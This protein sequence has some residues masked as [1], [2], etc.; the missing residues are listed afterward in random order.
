[1]LKRKFLAILIFLIIA[2]CAIS[3]VNAEEISHNSEI[4]NEDIS[5]DEI[6]TEEQQEEVQSIEDTSEELG[7]DTSTDY[8]TEIENENTQE[9]QSIDKT[10][11]TANEKL[12]QEITNDNTQDTQSEK[13]TTESNVL[14]SQ[15]DDEILSDGEYKKAKI[16]FYKQT[17]SNLFD[18]KIYLKVTDAQ[19]GELITSFLTLLDVNIYKNGKLVEA[20]EE[21]VD[22][23]S[24]KG[25][26]KLYDTFDINDAGTYTFKIPKSYIDDG[27]D[28]YQTSVASL[29]VTLKKVKATITAKKLTVKQK[30]KKKL[31]IKVNTPYPYDY[32][33]VKI[34][35]YTKNKV[36]SR[37]TYD[38]NKKGVVYIKVPQL[39]PGKHKVTINIYDKGITGKKTTYIIVKGKQTVAIKPTKL[40]TTYKSGKYFKAKVINKN[41]KKAVKGVKITLKVFTGKNAKTVTLKSNSKGII[42]Y[43]TS[44]L[45]V[46]THKVVL[47]VKKSKYYT[48]KTKTSTIKIYKK[49][50][51]PTKKTNQ[52]ST[53]GKLRTKIKI[54]ECY[55][56]NNIGEYYIE[57]SLKDSKGHSLSN[58]DIKILTHINL[59]G[60]SMSETT[61]VT[62][63]SKGIAKGY[64][65]VMMGGIA[66]YDVEVKFAGDKSH[67]S[68]TASKYIG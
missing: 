46:G 54:I 60:M 44:K 2:T 37:G 15:V 53:S 13:T 64:V 4:I 3:A 51:T 5:I 40:S 20:Q 52:K 59:G 6:T 1:M 38:T 22:V 57:L 55:R 7:E 56:T 19:T 8:V 25:V 30:S 63:D 49:K 33:T 50:T 16:T 39:S 9:I 35:I 12:T 45:K 27:L 28:I 23:S 17:G 47:K 48:G 10:T 26:I 18:K 43:S 21:M 34:K 24:G 41:T 67:Y 68:S 66:T 42:K 14:T 36:T 32:T 65:S 29:K 31:K 61:V 11:D 58:K 62:T